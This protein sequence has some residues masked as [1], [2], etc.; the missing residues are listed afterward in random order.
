[1]TDR[2]GTHRPCGPGALYWLSG[3]P[4]APG[5]P[6]RV[7]ASLRGLSFVRTSQPF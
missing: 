3:L 1:M 2:E 5:R 4:A 7:R 6:Y